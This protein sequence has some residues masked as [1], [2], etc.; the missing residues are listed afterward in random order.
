M[1]DQENVSLF[2]YI[3]RA[4]VEGELPKD[5]RLPQLMEE[6][7]EIS[8][9]WAD[10]ALDG[11]TIYHV[12]LPAPTDESLVLMEKA[13]RTAADRKYD[14]AD[15]YFTELGKKL[16]AIGGIDAIQN[17]IIDHKDELNPGN[18]FEYAVHAVVDSADKECIKYGLS[19]LELFDIEQNESIK[20][21]VRTIGLSDE[22][23]LFAIFIMLSWEDGN[24]EVFQLAK[25]VH[26]WGRI[27]AVERIEPT[28][29]EIK[30]W[31][32]A[33]A[34][35]NWIMPA[36]S[37]LTCWEKSGADSV[38]RGDLNREEFSGLRDII[39][40]LL[41]EGSVPGISEI[42]NSDDV[43]ITF[44]NQAK[45]LASHIDDYE[46][47]R[48][49]RIHFEDEDT[50]NPNIVDLCREILSSD[51]CMAAVKG[52]VVRGQS[53]P[54]A[55]ELGIDYRADVFKVLESDFE[56]KAHVCDTLLDDSIYRR[57]VLDLFRQKLSLAEIKTGPK[58]TLGMG[59]NYWKED[60]L[61]WLM[62]GLRNYPV[63][64]QE[65]VEAG[66]QAAP[67]RTRNGAI[68]VLEKWVLAKE[69][70]LADFLPDFQTLLMRL[71]DVEPDEQIKKR[72]EKLVSGSITFADEPEEDKEVL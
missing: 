17:F 18:V 41:D 1:S 58:K 71:K 22:F 27:H 33:D 59:K 60:A 28:T 65:F 20:N 13:V 64:G 12:R 10:G 51:S 25:K 19:M 40:G 6:K 14:T 68:Y 32:L 35:H 11:A 56:E 50:G 44:L 61:E 67:V 46:V 57:K 70:P 62:Q 3:S 8:W 2:Q 5:F 31:L 42:E 16:S 38:L 72:M 26:G 47:I 29:K 54:L 7:N 52:A 55:H 66:L 36:Y 43:I 53:I 45:N 49:I 48:S 63:E 9:R 37:A 23:S 21:V 24:N 30:Y 34:V 15:E 4:V 69:K 39:E